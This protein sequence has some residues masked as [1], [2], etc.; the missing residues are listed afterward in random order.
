MNIVVHIER[1]VLDGVPV[2]QSERAK[3]RAALE[4]ELTR[5]LAIRGLTPALL[6]GGTVL[7]MS[8]GKLQIDKNGDPEKLGRQIAQAVHI[9]EGAS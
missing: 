4:A 8:A 6:E 7:R 3:L 5:L 2:A 1:L 9:Y